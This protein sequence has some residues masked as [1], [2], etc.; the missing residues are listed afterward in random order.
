MFKTMED[1]RK[2]AGCAPG[3]RGPEA[4]ATQLELELELELSEGGGGRG[5]V[6]SLEGR[7][8]LRAMSQI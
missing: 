4:T 2:G 7:C 1:G 6:T 3:L 8:G 5:C